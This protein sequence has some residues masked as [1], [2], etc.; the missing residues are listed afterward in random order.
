MILNNLKLVNKA[1]ELLKEEEEKIN[2]YYEPRFYNKN[3]K[4]KRHLNYFEL[5]RDFI[6]D[7]IDYGFCPFIEITCE[8]QMKNKNILKF[9]KER[10][11]DYTQHIKKLNY[12]IKNKKLF[13]KKSD[14][15]SNSCQTIKNNNLNNIKRPKIS[16][17]KNKTNL[18]C[19]YNSMNGIS[20]NKKKRN[21]STILNNKK[22]N[23][24][25]KTKIVKFS[26]NDIFDYSKMKKEKLLENELNT[27]FSYESEDR[28][29]INDDYSLINNNPKKND[30][31]N[32]KKYKKSINNKRKFLFYN[33]KIKSNSHIIKSTLEKNLKNIKPIKKKIKIKKNLMKDTSNSTNFGGKNGFENLTIAKNGSSNGHNIRNNQRATSMGQ[34]EKE[35][36]GIFKNSVKYDCLAKKYS[37]L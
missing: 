34:L 10:N 24:N 33:F 25:E 29:R 26:R 17:Y 6:N 28:Y 2:Y 14:D 5:K 32:V 8:E 15:K 4:W 3:K 36:G 31:S 21:L 7:I 35:S 19:L 22:I 27:S 18:F 20:I 23:E 9:Y 1:F 30:N 16:E 13:L 12:F 11:R 37:Y